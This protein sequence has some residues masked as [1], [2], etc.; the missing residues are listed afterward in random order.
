MNRNG[1]KTKRSIWENMVIGKQGQN[2]SNPDFTHIFLLVITDPKHL[3][4]FKNKVLV[5]ILLMF[6]WEFTKTMSKRF[7]SISPMPRNTHKQRQRCLPEGNVP[8]RKCGLICFSLNCKLALAN[9]LLAQTCFLLIFSWESV[10]I[11]DHVCL[12]RSITEGLNLTLMNI[13]TCGEVSDS[14][15]LTTVEILKTWNFKNMLM[16]NCSEHLTGL[17]HGLILFMILTGVSQYSIFIIFYPDV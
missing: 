11:C 17:F 1:H 8:W 16:R 13:N 5:I 2:R 12:V 9:V 6:T 7:F 15:D 4:K 10:M 14:S 3:L